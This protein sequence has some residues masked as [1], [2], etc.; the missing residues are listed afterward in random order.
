MIRKSLPC[1]TSLKLQLN[2][3][4]NLLQAHSSIKLSIKLSCNLYSLYLLVINLRARLHQST[5]L[6]QK[7]FITYSQRFTKIYLLNRYHRSFG[8]YHHI[9]ALQTVRQKRMQKILYKKSRLF[10][11]REI[12]PKL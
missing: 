10:I 8:M 4:K 2:R 12:F 5:L 7:F 11:R 3:N 9:S 6:K 1:S